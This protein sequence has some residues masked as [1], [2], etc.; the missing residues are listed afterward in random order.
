[1]LTVNL[2]INALKDSFPWD[3]L[4][5]TVVDVGG[6]S[7]KVSI[8]LAQVTKPPSPALTQA[9]IGISAL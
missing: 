7:G 5:G 2:N 3:N 8:T 6:G 4:K 1:M 9:L